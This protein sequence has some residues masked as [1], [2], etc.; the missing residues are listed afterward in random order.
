MDS[1]VLLEVEMSSAANT[2]ILRKVYAF[3][4]NTDLPLNAGQTL[5]T[6]GLGGTSWISVLSTLTLAGGSAVG[7]LPSTLSSISSVTY[8]IS[9]NFAGLSSLSTDMYTAISSL[10]RKITDSLPTTA[11]NNSLTSTTASLGAQGFISTASLTSSLAGVGQA[12]YASTLSS[13]TSTINA[14][15]TLGF[16]STA[17][18]TSTVAGLGSLGY[19]STPLGTLL[20]ATELTSSVIGLGTLGYVSSVTNLGNLGY[21]SSLSL[22]STVKG[23][24]SAGYVSSINLTSTVA[25]LGTAGYISTSA[26]VST[27]ASL[28]S[29][30]ANI[31]FDTTGNVVVNG[32]NTVTF[33][34]IGNIIYIS[35][36]LQS[37]ITY[38]GPQTGVPI[39]A[40]K[41]NNVDMIFS[42]AQIDFSAFS[43][44]MNSTSRVTLDVYPS[45]AFTKLATGATSPVVLPLSTM[46]QYGTTILSSP[47]ITTFLYVGN[48]TVS[49]ENGTTVDA[50]NMYTTPIKLAF[51]PSS[52]VGRT[53]SPYTLVHLL[54]SSL[55]YTPF[56]NALHTNVVTPYFSPAGS[57][58]VSVQ[59]IPT[60]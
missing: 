27:V 34:T 25:G 18:L 13:G 24:G 22:A 31:R 48:T 2:T 5:V 30:K 46:I 3:D 42:T 51:P 26:L 60:N 37:S 41:V 33:N 1:R 36:F 55:N 50:S 45:F 8:M 57:V 9:L 47:C 6:D 20:T 54:P 53:A 17:S 32:G 58:Y 14:L 43:M 21:I 56:I 11:A 16:I 52:I 38:T 10:G 15:G 12:T 28:S 19:S 23:L 7:N 44:F 39:T 29:Q 4:S 40:Q 49:L 59:N 35:S